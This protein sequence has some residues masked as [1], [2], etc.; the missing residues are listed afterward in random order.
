PIRSARSCRAGDRAVRRA[1]ARLA[2]R[3]HVAGGAARP[4]LIR[5]SGRAVRGCAV[6]GYSTF[7]Q[8]SRRPEMLH[9][10]LID[11]EA[12]RRARAHITLN[13]YRDPRKSIDRPTIRL[14]PKVLIPVPVRESEVGRIV[15]KSPTGSPAMTHRRNG[16]R[17]G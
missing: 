17:R 4:P 11:A 10:H 5:L 1:G 6:P 9:W 15:P 14:W 3:A 7:S 2:A 8:C 16:W 13:E 12:C